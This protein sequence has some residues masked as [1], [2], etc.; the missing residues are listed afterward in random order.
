[1][2]R[3]TD[4]AIAHVHGLPLTAPP[5]LAWEELTTN[6]YKIPTTNGK[7]VG[8]HTVTRNGL[9]CADEHDGH[10]QTNVSANSSSDH[11]L[12]AG[13]PHQYRVVGIDKS[14]PGSTHF[15]LVYVDLPKDSTKK[16]E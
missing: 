6:N 7:P 10:A 2:V 5:T 14:Q 15:G 1:V 3:A 16:A 9:T 8:S 12:R 13:T 11:E 4:S